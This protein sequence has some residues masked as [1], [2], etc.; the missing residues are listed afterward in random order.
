MTRVWR[1]QRFTLAEVLVAIVLTAVVLP[2]AV[3]GML[4]ANR[5]GAVAEK[6]MVAARLAERLLS[7]MIITQTWTGDTQ[8]GDCGT[9][10][11]GFNW[12]RRCETWN[13]YEPALEVVTVDVMFSHQG[14]EYS[15]HLST[16]AAE[17]QT[18]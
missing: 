12:E 13:D 8:S 4:I 11:P 14:H 18:Q 5:A 7:E 15:V 17:S 10:Y 16:L 2:V 6:K 3:R 1:T 9:D